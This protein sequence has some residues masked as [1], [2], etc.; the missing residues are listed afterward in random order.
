MSMYYVFVKIVYMKIIKFYVFF[1][2]MT[3]S[4][5]ITALD[6]KTLV[7]G[8]LSLDQVPKTDSY[9]YSVTN[10][11]SAPVGFEYCL[12]HGVVPTIF[13]TNRVAFE[14][15]CDEKQD[16]CFSNLKIDFFERLS[17][18]FSTAIE[19]GKTLQVYTLACPIVKMTAQKLH[20][21]LPVLR[22]PWC[23]QCYDRQSS[24][25]ESK[26]Q[27]LLK[28]RTFKI[29]DDNNINGTLSRNFYQTNKKQKS[30]IEDQKKD[31]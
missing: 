23:M 12:D 1:T 22:Y 10:K 7:I 8:I 5:S 14:V 19:P 28:Y 3:V 13:A 2:L 9:R 21:E 6:L 4:Y 30:K 17:R 25:I 31:L 24:S 26:T 15:K 18:C 11:L 20:P 16:N 29:S 27:E